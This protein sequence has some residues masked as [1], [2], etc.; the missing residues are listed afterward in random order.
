MITALSRLHFPSL[1]AGSGIAAAVVALSSFAIPVPLLK[2]LRIL[3]EPD[4]S[5]IVRIQEGDSCVVPPK[6]SLVIKAA[7]V[8]SDFGMGAARIKING[9]PVLTLRIDFQ[10]I[11]ALP[12]PLV[13]QA[14]DVVTVEDVNADPNF[15]PFVTGYLSE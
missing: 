12:F 11:L 4:P 5:S 15:R 14:G 7:A 10:E 13:A 3:L 6:L 8:T 2:T 1:V 9:T